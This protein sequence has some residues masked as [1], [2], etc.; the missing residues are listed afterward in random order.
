MEEMTPRPEIEITEE[1]QVPFIVEARKRFLRSRMMPSILF[2]SVI[3]AWR[4]AHLIL[5][6]RRNDYETD[7]DYKEAI[8]DPNPYKTTYIFFCLR[9]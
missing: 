3:D 4:N 8:L 6:G 1:K 5:I 2:D 9:K 7:E